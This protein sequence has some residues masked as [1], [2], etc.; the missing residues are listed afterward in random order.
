[1]VSINSY[2]LSIFARNTRFGSDVSSFVKRHQ[3]LSV[4]YINFA[5]LLIVCGFDFVAGVM[6]GISG[7][8][9]FTTFAVPFVIG[10]IFSVHYNFADGAALL[11]VVYMNGMNTYGTTL[12]N[13]PMVAFYALI[14]YPNFIF[15]TTS[16]SKIHHLNN[17]LVF[18]NLIF[19]GS[20]VLDIFKLTLTEEQHTQVTTFIVTGGVSITSIIICCY[21]QKSIETNLWEL[22]RKKL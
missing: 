11:M 5:F 16:N 21:I 9:T 6:L 20:K 17:V 18:S 12:V 7:S 10:I 1:M 13:V 22:A 3:I 14:L 4:I 19:S 2:V 15:F 8:G